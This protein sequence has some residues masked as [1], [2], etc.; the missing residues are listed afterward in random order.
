MCSLHKG[1]G[2][3]VSTGEDKSKIIIIISTVEGPK[4]YTEE[5]LLKVSHILT[6]VREQPLGQVYTHW[7][8]KLDSCL[9]GNMRRVAELEQCVLVSQGGDLI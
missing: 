8:V 4:A 1:F 9:L 5:G 2:H 7:R 6:H 3:R